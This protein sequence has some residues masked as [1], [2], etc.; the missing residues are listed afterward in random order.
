[1]NHHGSLKKN[2]CVQS[3]DYNSDKKIS[4][5]GILYN[6]EGGVKGVRKLQNRTEKLAKTATLHQILPKCRNCSYKCGSCP[7]INT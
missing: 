6:L 1:M 2:D 4:Q 7:L 3:S 5:T